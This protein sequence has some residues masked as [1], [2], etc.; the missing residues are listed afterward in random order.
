MSSMAR[1]V[2][3]IGGYMFSGF[4]QT[5]LR[6]GALEKGSNQRFAETS[7]WAI[8]VISV[9][10]LASNGVGYQS[11]LRVRLIHSMVRKH[12]AALPD[13]GMSQSTASRLT[14]QT[15]RPPWSAHS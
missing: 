1:D 12:V 9:D 4:N 7:Q 13:C 5:L 11:T 15:W 14:K 3:L 8:D 6:T 2:V 10:G